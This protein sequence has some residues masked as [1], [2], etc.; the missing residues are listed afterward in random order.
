MAAGRTT[1]DNLALRSFGFLGSIWSVLAYLILSVLL[2]L[3]FGEFE[4]RA[5][6]IAS[7]GS[8]SLWNSTPELN[9]LNNLLTS[10]QATLVALVFPVEISLV[11]FLNGQR[12]AASADAILS[13]YRAESGAFQIAASSFLLLLI[14]TGTLGVRA[15]YETH[16]PSVYGVLTLVHLSWLL[17][18]LLGAIYFGAVSVDFATT[19]RSRLVMRHTVENLLP[20]DAEHR[21]LLN[22]MAA[23]LNRPGIA[24]GHLV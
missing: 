17:A 8:L 9:D 15:V 5:G 11:T 22:V 12:S 2:V 16:A 23:L 4:F 10:I 6:T 21:L 3:G 24:G 20:K 19:K 18:N 13:A 1:I 7:S 14:L